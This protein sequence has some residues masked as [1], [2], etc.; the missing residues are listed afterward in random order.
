MLEELW[1]STVSEFQFGRSGEGQR[2]D[3]KLGGGLDAFKCLYLIGYWCWDNQPKG[4]FSQSRFVVKVEIL[5]GARQLA[6]LASV[7]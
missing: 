7:R 1:L 5:L 4:P 2:R 3:V 6:R